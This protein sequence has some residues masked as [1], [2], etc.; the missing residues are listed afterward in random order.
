M[1]S[2]FLGTNIMPTCVSLESDQFGFDDRHGFREGAKVSV[3][4]TFAAY[5]QI[6]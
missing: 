4:I 6:P 3:T 5:A 1:T 2:A